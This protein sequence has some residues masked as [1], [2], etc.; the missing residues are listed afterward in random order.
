MDP[1]PKLNLCFLAAS[2][3]LATAHGYGVVTGTVFCDQCK[4]GQISMFDY[5]MN[6]V[7]VMVACGDGNGGVTYLREETTNLFGSFTMRFD[8]TP[9]LSGCYA[10]VGG[11]AE[12]TTTDCGGAG[13]PPK[14]L[15]LMF[16]LFDM[17]MYVVDSLVSQPAKP[18]SFC[19]ASV[20]PV[21]VPAPV[22]T[23]P[24][25]P[26]LPLPPLPPSFKLPPLPPLPQLPP[27]PFLEAS[28]CQH[29][30]WTNPDYRCYWRA[31]NP[32]TKVAVIFGLGA[33][34]RYGTD[35]TLWNGLQ[36]RGDPYRTLLR[37][38]ITAFLNSYNSVNFPYPTLSVVQRL[39]WALLGS[40]R[41]VLLTALRFKRANSGYGHVTCKFDPCQ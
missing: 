38:A 35:L 2:L 21:P 31:V 13:G 8:G 9:D 1:L 14:S 16:R 24:P 12:G 23:A 18:M 25:S 40:P 5:P 15:R 41:A 39:N 34:N 6:G 11:S 26:S 27:G 20:N 4:D 3:L 37:E 28:A 19:S 36:G 17:E 33:A 7:K 10:T 30:N 32:D 22:V 29:E